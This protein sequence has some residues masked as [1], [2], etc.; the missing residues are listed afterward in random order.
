MTMAVLSTVSVLARPPMISKIQRMCPM[1]S[2]GR[3]SQYKGILLRLFVLLALSNVGCKV[4]EATKHQFH[5]SK[6]HGLVGP[7]GV[8]FGFNAHGKFELVVNDF[9]L[10]V[11]NDGDIRILDKVEAGFFLQKFENEAAFNQHMEYL[12]SNT[13]ACA[14]AHFLASNDNDAMDDIHEADDD[15]LGDAAG[16]AIL[17]AADGI[18][19][20]MKSTKKWKPSKPSISY[21]FK[22]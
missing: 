5:F 21:R 11:K 12:R 8:P 3:A 14:F 17:S 1:S 22:A 10:K 13:S 6:A 16:G 7:V 9:E 4:V 18:F 2:T 15:D 19:L 20:S